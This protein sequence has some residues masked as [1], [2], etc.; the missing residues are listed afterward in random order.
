MRT[1][2]RYTPTTAFGKFPWPQPRVELR[3]AV[4]IV[5]TRLIVR[6]GAICLERQIGLTRLY[7]EVEDG[8]YQDLARLHRELDEAVAATYGWP[9]AAANDPAESNR[10]LLELNRAI[11]AGAVKYRPFPDEGPLA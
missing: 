8:A 2:I 7:N 9:K 5:A 4:A 10:R 3:E 1:D 11:S 6:R